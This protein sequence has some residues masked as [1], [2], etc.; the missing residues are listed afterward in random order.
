VLWNGE[1]NLKAGS[2]HSLFFCG[3]TTSVDTLFTTDIIPYYRVTDSLS[4]IRFV[5]LVK[6]SLPM[7]IN[8]QGNLSSQAEFDNLGYKEMSNFKSYNVNGSGPG[9][10]NFE[11]RDQ[12]SDSILTVFSWSY[13]LEQCNTVFITGSSTIG[14]NAY[15][16]NNF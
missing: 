2:I 9:S 7:S 14:I 8:I 4:G 13:T 11:I 10:Y 16:L 12:N 15:Q 6:G 5:N 1:I 3:D